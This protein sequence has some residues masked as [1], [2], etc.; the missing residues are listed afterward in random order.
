[1]SAYGAWQK[2][3]FD[4]GIFLGDAINNA[5]YNELRWYI[6]VLDGQTISPNSD[7]KAIAA[8]DYLRQFKAAGLDKSIPWYQVLG[9]HDHFWSGVYPPNERIKS[10]G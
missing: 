7:P 5:Q 2:Q 3:A 1:M 9:N 8:T 4:F 10:K 6:D